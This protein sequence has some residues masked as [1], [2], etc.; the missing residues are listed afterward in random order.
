[1][2]KAFTGCEGRGWSWWAL[3]KATQG[4]RHRSWEGGDPDV[5]SLML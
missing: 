4:A 1:M 2:N 5:A 3:G